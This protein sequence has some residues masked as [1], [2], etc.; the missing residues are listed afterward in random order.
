MT[1][2]P[3]GPL[4]QAWIDAL[5]SGK[6]E[7]TERRLRLAD[8]FCCLGV[9]CDL[10]PNANWVKETLSVDSIQIY[11]FEGAV[12]TPTDSLLAQYKIT[13]AYEFTHLN[14]NKN[15]TFN[16]IADA[17]EANPAEFFSEPA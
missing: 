13:S 6:Y 9:L 7:Q 8:R 4:Q 2:Q 11:S 1:K 16:E 5:R 3:L 14:D 15:Y 10:Q 17:V 12:S